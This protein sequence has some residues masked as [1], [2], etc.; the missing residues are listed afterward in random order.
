MSPFYFMCSLALF[1]LTP[2]S[3][4]KI[5]ILYYNEYSTYNISKLRY[6]ANIS[7]KII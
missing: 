4:N 1:S 7:L 5:D 2:S 3:G 6:S